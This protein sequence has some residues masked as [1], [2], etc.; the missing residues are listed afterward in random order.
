MLYH[1]QE[2]TIIIPKYHYHD[3][4]ITI[5]THRYILTKTW[6][7]TFDDAYYIRLKNNDSG[8]QFAYDTEQ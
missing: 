5:I 3:T 4:V 7:K 6:R 2:P 1:N 8:C